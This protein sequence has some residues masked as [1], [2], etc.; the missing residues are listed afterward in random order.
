MKQNLAR[1]AVDEGGTDGGKGEVERL[2]VSQHDCAFS[3]LLGVNPQNSVA[4]MEGIVGVVPN[5]GAC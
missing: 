2:A 1:A 3:A 5:V 4:G